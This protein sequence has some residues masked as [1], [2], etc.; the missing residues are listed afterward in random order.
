M[1]TSQRR[2]AAAFLAVPL[3]LLSGCMWSTRKLPIPKPPTIT[4]TVAPDELVKRLN[5]NWAS[6]ESLNA[7][8]EIQA[9]VTKTKEGTARDYTSFRGHI[10]IRKPEMLRVLGQVPVLGT[11]MFDMASDGKNFTLFVPSKSL[12][13]KGAN[14]LRK[15][16]TSQVENMRPGFFFDAMVVRGLNPDDLYAVV[17]DSETVEDVA[18]KHLF[19][20]P[21]YILS[22]SRRKP[23]T[24]ELTPVRVVTFRRDDLMPYQQDIY[25]SAGNL[26]TQVIYSDY[27]DFDSVM[28]PVTITIKRPLE[29]YQLVLTVESV[30]ENMTLSD[31][32]FQ[33]KIPDGTK[34][35][36]L[37]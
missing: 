36:N 31:D 35:Q 8:V 28:F 27:E 2:A 19:T 3:L 21:K 18:R 13:V 6:L 20:V 1:K 10:L 33:I 29:E 16:S 11:R 17:A 5:K 37:E 32:Q 34:I 22:I 15:K 24:N 23:G 25:D 7:T 9:S 4:Q 12:A 14:D 30:K 26:E